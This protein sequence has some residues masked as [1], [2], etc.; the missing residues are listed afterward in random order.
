MHHEP[1]SGT[2]LTPETSTSLKK[3]CTSKTPKPRISGLCAF[4]QFF[5]APIASSGTRPATTL[6]LPSFGDLGTGRPRI[7]S[8]HPGCLMRIASRP[9]AV[10]GALVQAGR[11]LPSLYPGL[12][13]QLARSPS[14]FWEPWY[15]QAGDSLFYCSWRW[16]S[17]RQRPSTFAPD[18][19]PRN[20]LAATRFSSKPPSVLRSRQFTSLSLTFNCPP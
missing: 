18:H 3:S 1:A 17:N 9:I 8:L 11:E 6:V 7:P 16:I 15:R 14:P 4:W 10:L 20:G 12:M 13:R 19:S 5:L 2:Y